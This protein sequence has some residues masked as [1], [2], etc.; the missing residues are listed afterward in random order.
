MST[1]RHV[2]ESVRQQ[3]VSSAARLSQLGL[4][5]GSSGNVSVREGDAI[6]MSPTGSDLAA[7]D[8]D[9]L[10]VLDFDGTLLDGPKASK[11]YPLHRA[12]Y[13]RRPTHRAVVHLHSSYASAVSCAPPWSPLSAVPP[14]TPY[15]VMR[16]GQTPLI[17]YS[18]PGDLAQS[19]L[20]EA[21]AFPF[22]A[23]LLQNHGL[24]TAG[25]TIESACDSAVELEEVCK[26]LLLLGSQPSRLLTPEEASRVAAKC[27]SPWSA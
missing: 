2:S 13:R 12:M 17:P 7:L 25:P 1:V 11:E 23:A 24:I 27:S 16:V 15:F 18:D 3:L 9:N 19:E 21:L 22:R 20:V 26:L 14:L 10:S 6:V 8:V 5:P 4:S